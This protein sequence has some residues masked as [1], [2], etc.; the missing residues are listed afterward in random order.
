MHPDEY[1]QEN[2]RRIERD[3][4]RIPQTNLKKR[5]DSRTPSAN[6]GAPSNQSTK[7]TVK[8]GLET[9]RDIKYPASL[10]GLDD[11]AEDSY[12]LGACLQTADWKF[13]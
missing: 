8:P 4:L 11:N 6:V 1:E 3:T 2:Y 10:R 13:R 7:R 5:T 9:C 12:L